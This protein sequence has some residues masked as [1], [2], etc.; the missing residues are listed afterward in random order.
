MKYLNYL[1]DYIRAIDI[2]L[3]EKFNLS[4]NNYMKAEASEFTHPNQL[5]V[6]NRNNELFSDEDWTEIRSLEKLSNE[7]FLK[8]WLIILAKRKHEFYLFDEISEI[9]TRYNSIIEFGSGQGHTGAFLNLSGSNVR[10]TELN[11]HKN[12]LLN[13]IE[14]LPSIDQEDIVNISSEKLKNYSLA[15]AVQVDYMLE[16]YVIHDFLLKS[17]KCDT[18]VLIVNHEIFGIFNYFNYK[19]KDSYRRQNFKK[20]GKKRTI[21]FYK[22]LAKKVGYKFEYKKGKTEIT[23]NYF[24]LH[25]KKSSCN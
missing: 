1:K 19:F 11:T 4:S 20:N 3:G 21:G 22:Q 2:S 12:L 5:K 8:S 14:D 7:S 17:Y 9:T 23:K 25:F 16:N 13:N 10:M 18:D 6:S 15:F 24:Y